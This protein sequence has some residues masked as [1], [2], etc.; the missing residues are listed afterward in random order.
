[1]LPLVHDAAARE[2]VKRDFRS[3][4]DWLGELVKRKREMA[5]LKDHLLGNSLVLPRKMVLPIVKEKRKLDS[6][7]GAK[8]FN[9]C[10]DLCLIS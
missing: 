10:T 3:R 1:M 5:L 6:I 8:E 2:D 4:L 7:L 9:H